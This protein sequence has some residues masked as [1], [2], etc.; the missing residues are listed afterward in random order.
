MKRI[1]IAAIFIC[2]SGF[3]A[4]AQAV[5]DDC[6][7]IT[8]ASPTWGQRGK[9][10]EFLVVVDKQAEKY[11]IEYLWSVSSGKI[12]SGQGSK[13]IT[14][15]SNKIDYLTAAVEIKGLPETC[16]KSASESY[17]H[18]TF[19]PIKVDEFD[20]FG[21]SGTKSR[22]DNFF[23]VLLDNKETEGVIVFRNGEDLLRNIKYVRDHAAFRNF[24]AARITIAISSEG[25]RSTQF[26]CL[27]PGTEL[28]KTSDGLLI[29]LED[30]EQLQKI[31]QPVK[32]KAKKS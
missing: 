18:E 27:P 20:N 14:V 11:N 10:M 12:V 15:I 1:I 32:T 8:V 24:P 3:T 25:E 5:N 2:L 21:G 22:I 28:S 7:T 30:F 31:F 4:F 13:M 29:K 19:S 16:P 17:I 6:P 9:P 23:I 26:W